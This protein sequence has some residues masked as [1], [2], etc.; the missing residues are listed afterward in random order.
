[1]HLRGVE[2][3]AP[4]LGVAQ[5]LGDL[6]VVEDPQ[7]ERTGASSTALP[8]VRRPQR[9]RGPGAVGGENTAA[10]SAAT[11]DVTATAT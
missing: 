7:A 4:G 3:D 11:T 5:H 6:G 9:E 1:M 2:A 10:R 8:S